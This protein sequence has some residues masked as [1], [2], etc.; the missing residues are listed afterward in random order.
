VILSNLYN[1]KPKWLR[2]RC[3][4][5]QN[6]LVAR[7]GTLVIYEANKLVAEKI[8]SAPQALMEQHR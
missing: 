8:K 6:Q 2:A 1:S 7:F 4:E 5:R 3:G